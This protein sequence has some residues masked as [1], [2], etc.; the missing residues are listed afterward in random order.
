[1]RTF[2][3]YLFFSEYNINHANKIIEVLEWD[4]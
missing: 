1:M 3:K 4:L 2:N